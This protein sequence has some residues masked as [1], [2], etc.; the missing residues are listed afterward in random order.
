MG[1]LDQ[2]ENTNFFFIIEEVLQFS[3]GT[4]KGYLGINKI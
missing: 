4:E 2:S 3:K 1:N